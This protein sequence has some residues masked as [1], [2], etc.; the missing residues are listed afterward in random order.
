VNTISKTIEIGEDSAGVITGLLSHFAK[1]QRVIVA[2]SDV[3]GITNQVPTLAEFTERIEAA[4]LK[5]PS[6]PWTKV[7]EAFRDLREGE[8]G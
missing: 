7:D 1:G 4:R 6:L 8:R 2:L 5:L 3:A